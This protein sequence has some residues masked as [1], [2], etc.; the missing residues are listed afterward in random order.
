MF[1][2]LVTGD[3]HL[4]VAQYSRTMRGEDFHRALMW[5][6][7]KAVELKVDAILNTGDVFNG[8]VLASRVFGQLQEADRYLQEAGIPMY[9]LS[10]NHEMSA[11]PWTAMFG[12]DGPGGI[13]GVDNLRVV[14]EKPGEKL[15]LHG[16]PF[17]P[18]DE[19]REALAAL[20]PCDVLMWHGAVREFCGFPTQ[21]AIS[22]TEFPEEK[23]GCAMLGDIHVHELH[24]LP[25]GTV[26]GYPGSTELYSDGEDTE[27]K[28]WLLHASA[29]VKPVRCESIPLQSRPV[30]HL[31]LRSEDD[32]DAAVAA[33]KAAGEMPLVFARYSLSLPGAMARLGTTFG[34][35]VCMLRAFPLP[36]LDAGRMD[37]GKGVEE[38]RVRDLVCE[39]LPKGTADYELALLLADRDTADVEALIDLFVE[40]QVSAA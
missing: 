17:M 29:G 11:P 35:D 2:L 22:E 7:R 32:M 21:T 24:T 25:G 6:V 26:I 38:L 14:L 27:K 12:C 36:A 3:N 28:A 34:P 30:V 19:M 37:A 8:S 15:V 16:L 23:I 33:V 9:T 39:F 5:V 20:E 13:K 4:R 1:N 31:E 10:G 18:A 40:Q